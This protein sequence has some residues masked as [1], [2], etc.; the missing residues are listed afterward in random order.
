MLKSLKSLSGR[1]SAV[2][3]HLIT[4]AVLAAANPARAGWIDGM[5]NAAQ[6]GNAGKA[7]AIAIFGFIGLCAVG[8]GGKLLWDKGGERGEDIKVS[9]IVFTLVGGAVMMALSY[10]GLQSIETLGGSAADMGR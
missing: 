6:L 3:N 5:T 10:I 2:R 1:L 8:F 7:T 9:R 4:M